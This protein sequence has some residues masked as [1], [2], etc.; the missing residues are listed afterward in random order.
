MHV[1]ST[2]AQN[3]VN[4]I[5]ET[6]GKYYVRYNENQKSEDPK[7]P[8][9]IFSKEDLSQDTKDILKVLQYNFKRY[10]GVDNKKIAQTFDKI[11]E[12]EG[13]W[14]KI[15]EIL[16]GG[17]GSWDRFISSLQKV[18]AEITE[19]DEK[20]AKEIEKQKENV[21]EKTTKKS[22]KIVKPSIK[23]YHE[24]VKEIENNAELGEDLKELMIEEL[25]NLYDKAF[26]DYYKQ[27]ENNK[28]DKITQLQ[29]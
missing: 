29:K 12:E 10:I 16:E 23:A 9:E 21:D 4:K 28:E 7:Y 14:K 20:Y 25:T 18:S 13:S 15:G 24:K 3:V 17:L 11:M 2:Y 19:F 1:T 8:G 22:T 6:I 27:N 26:D 5:N